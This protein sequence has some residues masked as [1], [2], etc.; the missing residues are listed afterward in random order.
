MLQIA[1]PEAAIEMADPHQFLHS[2]DLA[3]TGIRR[4]NDQEARQEVIG[5]RFLVTRHGDGTAAFDAL[6]AMAE[7]QRHPHIPARFFCGS[8]RI[9]LVIRHIDG[10]LRADQQGAR[11]IELCH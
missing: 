9:G 6:V 1:K 2:F 8:P 11:R 4:A 5:L 10:T 7:T 3:Y